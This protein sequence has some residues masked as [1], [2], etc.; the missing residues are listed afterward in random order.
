MDNSS[1]LS[2]Q[3]KRI[4]LFVM[5]FL[6]LSATIVCF[7]AALL[8]FIFR[9]HKYFAHRL[10]LYQVLGALVRA[11]ALTLELLI[12]NYDQN[13]RIYQP[14]CEAV[15]FFALYTSWIK[16]LFASWVVLHLFCYSVF[17][18]NLQ[19]LEVLFIILSV[20]L[21]LLF[22]WV[23]FV[24]NSFGLSG[25]WCWIKNW[26]ND[27]IE[28]K[29]LDGVIE[30]F[31]LWYGPAMLCSIADTLAIIIIIS[32]LVC[33][34]PSSDQEPLLNQGQRKKALKE[35]LPLLVYPIIFC[36]VLIP[37]MVNRIYGAVSNMLNSNLVLTS[38]VAIPLQSFFAGLALIIHICVLKCPKS[39]YSWSCRLRQ[40]G[41]EQ[42]SF[43]SD[44][45]VSWK[46]T[47]QR[48]G[49]T[50]YRTEAFVPAESE[51]DKVVLSKQ[52][53]HASS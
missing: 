19:H 2:E 29:I 11:V 50:S 44:Q 16:L 6:G 52:G 7:A 31:S 49:C 18:K 40:H 38:A 3:E 33:C 35:L 34:R 24:N 30:Q 36:V 43:V 14:I 23:P 47:S 53:M 42:Q 48:D 27:S 10:A 9:L 8:V 12:L 51:V 28:H 17:Y 22:V 20:C 45:P 39:S 32:H 26:K 5:G 41:P 15:G 1:E 21:P 37:A 4:A 13:V 25:A 46:F